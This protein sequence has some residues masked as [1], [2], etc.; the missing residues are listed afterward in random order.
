MAV[1]FDFFLA[2]AEVISETM[3]VYYIIYF[4]GLQKKDES[5]SEAK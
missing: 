2:K 5:Q 3:Q 1:D 4:G